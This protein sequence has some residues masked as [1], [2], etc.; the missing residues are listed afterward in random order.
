MNRLGRMGRFTLTLTTAL[1]VAAL[2]LPATTLGASPKIMFGFEYDGLHLGSSCVA[3][4][5]PADSD[6]HL[7]WKSSAGVVKANVHIQSLS[8]GYWSYCSTT[9]TLAAQDVLR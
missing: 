9:R 5:A 7:V 4:R 6:V 1:V 8:Y 3:G 2:I